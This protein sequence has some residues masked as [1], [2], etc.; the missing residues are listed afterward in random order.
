M[1]TK[2][3]PNTTGVQVVNFVY[4]KNPI[5]FKVNGKV[6]ISA[7]QMA[8]SFGVNKKP[9]LWLRTDQAQEF[10]SES[11]KVRK[12]TLLDL[13]HVKYGGKTPG[14][15]MHEDVALEFARWLSPAFAIWCNDRIKDLLLARCTNRDLFSQ[16]QLDYSF[17]EH[18]KEKI[19]KLPEKYNSAREEYSKKSGINLKGYCT[20]I[21][22]FTWH[23]DQS[24]EWNLTQFIAIFNNNMIGGLFA[25]SQYLKHEKES[26]GLREDMQEFA[27]LL[28]KKYRIF[29]H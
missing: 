1:E 3:N 28:H 20:D 2:N 29:P 12:C 16:A 21:I 22:S 17:V 7:T 24:L 11:S 27:N 23:D 5:T 8:K 13:V 15:W 25:L 4:E 18:M 9:V 19:K 10:L 26:R 14:T 6:M